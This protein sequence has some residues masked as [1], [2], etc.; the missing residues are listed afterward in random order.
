MS[1]TAPQVEESPSTPPPAGPRCVPGPRVDIARNFEPVPR[2][3]HQALRARVELLESLI[4]GLL[5][6]Q[7]RCDPES[8]RAESPDGLL[9]ATRL[10]TEAEQRAEI[11]TVATDLAN[12]VREHRQDPEQVKASARE[13]T[14]AC[15]LAG[16]QFEVLRWRS[17]LEEGKRIGMT[18]DVLDVFQE[19]LG[20]A[21][22]ELTAV[23]KKANVPEQR[24]NE[25]LIPEEVIEDIWRRCESS[26]DLVLDLFREIVVPRGDISWKPGARQAI[27]I[28]PACENPDRKFYLNVETTTFNC[29]Q[30]ARSGNLRTAMKTYLKLPFR[31][32]MKY[33]GDRVGIIIEDPKPKKVFDL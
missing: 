33:L 4:T 6:F 9:P 32:M 10:L 8:Y 30:C 13:W 19:H 3:E 26:P 14:W 31:D 29:F 25:W 12:G 11:I 27:G 18:T 28:C 2:Q 23:T 15:N 17:L 20:R 24:V 1:E 21:E 22:L 5:T 7:Q 16:L